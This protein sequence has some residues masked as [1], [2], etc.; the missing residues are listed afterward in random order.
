MNAFDYKEIKSKIDEV[1][2]SYAHT[3]DDLSLN[4]GVSI[5]VDCDYGKKYITVVAYNTTMREAHNLAKHI[6]ETFFK[7]VFTVKT[8]EVW[9]P[10]LRTPKKEIRPYQSWAAGRRW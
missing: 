8:C 7:D 4:W 5:I 1:K 2:T 3:K 9:L 10:S 6:K